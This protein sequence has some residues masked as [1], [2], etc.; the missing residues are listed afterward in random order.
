MNKWASKLLLTQKTTNARRIFKHVNCVHHLKKTV[1]TLSV[2]IK[3][4]I[5]SD[6]LKSFLLITFSSVRNQRKKYIQHESS[7]FSAYTRTQTEI[8]FNR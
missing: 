1:T 7:F 8:L 6:M 4:T 5:N 3:Q 2:K